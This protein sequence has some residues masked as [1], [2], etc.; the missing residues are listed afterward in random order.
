MKT[1][2][3][4]ENVNKTHTQKTDMKKNYL[5]KTKRKL[6]LQKMLSGFEK[7]YFHIFNK[8]FKNTSSKIKARFGVIRNKKRK[9]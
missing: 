9:S 3:T 5:K 2:S 4:V 6:R 1:F 7:W 8:Y